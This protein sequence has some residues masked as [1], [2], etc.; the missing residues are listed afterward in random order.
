MVWHSRV[1]GPVDNVVRFEQRPHTLTPTLTS[2]PPAAEKV[3]PVC[4]VQFSQV[5]CQDEVGIAY[6][7]CRE[8]GCIGFYT[9]TKI[10]I[11]LGRGYAP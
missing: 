2:V 6:V 10:F 5:L 11:S 3:S 9:T 8:E 1:A 7:H 4:T